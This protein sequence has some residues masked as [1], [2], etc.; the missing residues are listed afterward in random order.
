MKLASVALFLLLSVGLPLSSVSAARVYV[1]PEETELNRL[2]TF[3]VPVRIDSEGTCINAVTATILYD[4]TVLSAV[5]T[6]RGN[7]ILTLWTE[8]PTIV[9][10]NDTEVGRVTFSGGIPG[11]YCGRVAGDP[12]LTNVLLRVA[13]T[14]VPK[15]LPV[16]ATERTSLLVDPSTL[17]YLHDGSGDAASTTVLGAELVLVQSTST[18]QNEWLSD[19]QSDTIAP[20]LFD[21]TLVPGPSVGNPQSYIVFSTTDKQ[22]G[23]DHYE[24]R[25]TDP[26]RFGFLTWLPERSSFFVEASSPYI[27][28]DQTLTSKI[29]VKAVDKNGNERVV[30]YTPPISPVREIARPAFLLTLLGILLVL[31]LLVHLVRRYLWVRRTKSTVDAAQP[32]TDPEADEPTTPTV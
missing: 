10:E 23:I 25:E 21:I 19:V 15:P 24:V 11:G 8:E 4:P 32:S 31:G 26:D 1:D 27:L 6:I 12:G 9:R 28:R 20:E 16:D 30:T 7:S 17:V 29:I 2:D 22:S 5:D 18:P 13:F 14:G 3:Y